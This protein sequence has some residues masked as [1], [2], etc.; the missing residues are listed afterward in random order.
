MLFL[1]LWLTLLLLLLLM[2]IACVLIAVPPYCCCCLRF[3]FSLLPFSCHLSLIYGSRWWSCWWSYFFF[4]STLLLLSCIFQFFFLVFLFFCINL[5]FYSTPVHCGCEGVL[6]WYGS[7]QA[8]SVPE[9][10]PEERET[11]CTFSSPEV[12]PSGKPWNKI[13]KVLL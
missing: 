8:L 6:I 1:L 7:Y 12:S 2:A 13:V 10:H 4:P 5:F 3:A 9:H 11:K